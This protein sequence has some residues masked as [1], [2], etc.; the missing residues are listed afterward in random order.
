M[1]GHHGGENLGQLLPLGRVSAELDSSNIVAFQCIISLALNALQEAD[2]VDRVLE[3]R[4]E[5]LVAN[6]ALIERLFI[7]AP[8]LG[9]LVAD[10]HNSDLIVIPLLFLIH[11]LHIDAS[12][13]L[14]TCLLE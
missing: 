6:T 10:H 2:G 8:H 9:V 4:E 5:V 12:R 11:I 13:A 7:W 14:I 3:W 1:V